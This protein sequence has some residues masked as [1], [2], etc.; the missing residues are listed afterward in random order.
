LAFLLIKC[1]EAL[2]FSLVRLAL[3]FR[4]L[5]R[6]ESREPLLLGLVCLTLFFHPRLTFPLR[7]SFLD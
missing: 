7:L 3:F 2:L 5:L 4:R 1:C 6:L